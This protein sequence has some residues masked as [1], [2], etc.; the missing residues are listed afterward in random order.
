M[1]SLLPNMASLQH[2]VF[3][4]DIFD[5]LPCDGILNA[6]PS[7]APNFFTSPLLAATEPVSMPATFAAGSLP[8]ITR[9]ASTKF[10]VK[11]LAFSPF[12]PGYD[13]VTNACPLSNPGTL[14]RCT[15]QQWN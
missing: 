1:A 11:V 7:S 13:A 14:Y 15:M 10:G 2:D 6:G 8:D 12:D 9:S 5:L 4:D 3:N